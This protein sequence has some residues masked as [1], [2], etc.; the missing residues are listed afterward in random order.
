MEKT[1]KID[2]DF[3]E[4]KNYFLEEN[5]KRNLISKNDEKFL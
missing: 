2:S 5:S 1:F 3:S 4:Y